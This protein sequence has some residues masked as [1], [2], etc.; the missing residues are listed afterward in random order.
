[1][2]LV[3]GDRVYVFYAAEPELYHTRLVLGH[4]AGLRRLRGGVER[5]QRGRR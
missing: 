1:M 5:L 4:V 3:E 2:S